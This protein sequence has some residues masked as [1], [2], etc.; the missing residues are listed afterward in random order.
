[1]ILQTQPDPRA[2]AICSAWAQYDRDC[3]QPPT[4][5]LLEGVAGVFADGG[6]LSDHEVRWLMERVRWMQQ[7][8]YRTLATAQA[9]SNPALVAIMQQLVGEADYLHGRIAAAYDLE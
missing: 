7:R 3:Q 2:A 8:Y 6:M 9:Q 5:G 1:M 4:A